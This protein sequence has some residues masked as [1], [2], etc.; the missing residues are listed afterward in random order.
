MGA[1]KALEVDFEQRREH[2]D[3]DAQLA[4]EARL[5]LLRHTWLVLL[6]PVP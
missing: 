5:G 4:M 6:D 2:I 1:Y 3:R